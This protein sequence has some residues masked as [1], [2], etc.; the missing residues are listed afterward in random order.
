LNDEVKIIVATIAFGMGIDKPDVRF[1]VHMDLPKN[2]E[3]YYQETGRAGRDGRPS[4]ALLFYTWADVLKLRGFVEVDGNPTQTEIMLGKLDKMAEFG[5]LK[6]CRRRFL[7]KYFSEDLQDECQNCD[8]CTT[9]FE[10]FNG[11]I[12]AQKALSAVHRTG[13]RF[14]LSYLIDFLRGSESAKIRDEHKELKTYGIGADISKENWFEYF[15]DLIDQGFLAQTEGQYPVIILTDKSDDVL[16]G[17]TSVELI[18]LKIR[19]E[20]RSALVPEVSILYHKDLLDELRQLR[21]SF[22][23]RENVPPYVI[24][25]DST[26]IEMAAYLPHGETELRR[27][28][29]VGDVK[30]EKYGSQ[31]LAAIDAFRLKNKLISQIELKPRRNRQKTRVKRD[32]TG[33]DTYQIS[34]EMFRSGLSVKEIAENRAVN[35]STVES[36]LA[37][38]VTTGEVGLDELVPVHKVEPI[39]DA[40]VKFNHTGALSLVKE[41]LGDGYSY[42][43]IRAVI[44]SMQVKA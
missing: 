39:K 21:T 31:F 18:K 17:K 40:V 24:F 1:V 38:F 15:R 33:K 4:E 41:F 16:K 20:K 26:L 27:I 11:T 7:L 37:R 36:H 19:D 3:S 30:L 22:A 29:G 8:N 35:V 28:T 34:L 43:E 23:K 32:G 14:G 42:G 25:S 2:I 44:A 6:T 10:R 13:Q 5:G 12:I 9:K